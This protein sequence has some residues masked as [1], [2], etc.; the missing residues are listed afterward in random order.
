MLCRLPYFHSNTIIHIHHKK[1]SYY[2]FELL[3]YSKIF[4]VVLMFYRLP[5][6][7]T[8]IN[9]SFIS[10]PRLNGDDFCAVGLLGVEWERA[11][12]VTSACLLQAQHSQ[13]NLRSNPKPPFSAGQHHTRTLKP[14]SLIYPATILYIIQKRQT[15]F[16]Y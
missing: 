15:V 14:T 4:Q 10:A 6:W 11:T 3:A 13:V 16:A 7:H 9:F 5:C 2:D 8:K 1:Y 12:F